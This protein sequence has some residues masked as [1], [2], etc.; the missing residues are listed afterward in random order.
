MPNGRPFIILPE[1]LTY[2]VTFDN[3]NI[4]RNVNGLKTMCDDELRKI[5]KL[6]WE[7]CDKGQR[8]PFPDV[9]HGLTCVA[10]TRKGT[11]CKQK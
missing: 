1:V 8:L 6:H 4:G 9:L 2:L 10:K 5:W 3:S 7:A 11:P